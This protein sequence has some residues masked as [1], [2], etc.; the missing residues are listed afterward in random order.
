MIEVHDTMDLQHGTRVL[1]SSQRV[2]ECNLG[3]G[4]KGASNVPAL[5]LKNVVRYNCPF[6]ANFTRVSRIRGVHGGD[7]YVNFDETKT[8]CKGLQG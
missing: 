3:L 4:L 8:T 5:T 6:L 1:T 2:L 7:A